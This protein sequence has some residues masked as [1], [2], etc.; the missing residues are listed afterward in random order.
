MALLVVR[1]PP[2]GNLKF[3]FCFYR[4]EVSNIRALSAHQH[5]IQCVNGGGRRKEVTR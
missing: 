1:S 4:G 5:E 2:S 3:A